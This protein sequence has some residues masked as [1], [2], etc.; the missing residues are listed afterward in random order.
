MSVAIADSPLPRASLGG[1]G[2]VRGQRVNANKPSKHDR[3]SALTTLQFATPRNCQ[4]RPLTP[5]L[6][7]NDEAVGGEGVNRFEQLCP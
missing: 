2:W 1:E 3:H 5:T 7:P 6:S 4:R